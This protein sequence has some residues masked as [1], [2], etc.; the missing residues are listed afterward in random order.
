M[1]RMITLSGETAS[2]TFDALWMGFCVG[3]GFALNVD[4][5]QAGQARD[6]RRA[7][8]AIK[9]SLEGVS[10]PAPDAPRLPF[11]NDA[12]RRVRDG[13][14]MVLEQAQIDTLVAYINRVPWATSSLDAC[15]QALDALSAAPTAAD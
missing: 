7:D 14:S 15:E 1:K 9:R 10:D 12:Q 11:F 2:D 4:N 5:K 6:A 13:A 8:L 3:R